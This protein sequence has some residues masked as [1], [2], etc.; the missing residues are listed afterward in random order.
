MPRVSTVNNKRVHPKL[1]PS[2]KAERR[3]KHVALA[4]DVERVKSAYAQ[5]AAH[6]A[7][8]HGRYVCV[9]LYYLLFSVL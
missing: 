4:Q 5:E 8:E 2:Q 7:R 6:L 3:A 1:T 9:I